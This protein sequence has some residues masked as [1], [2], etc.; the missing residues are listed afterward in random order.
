MSNKWRTLR[1]RHRR[2]PFWQEYLDK[3][4]R[5]TPPPEF[6]KHPLMAADV[7]SIPVLLELLRDQ[8]REIRLIAAEALERFGPEGRE[9]VP[10]LFAALSNDDCEV[11]LAVEDAIFHIDHEAAEKAG[12]VK[13]RSRW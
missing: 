5:R 4:V 12:L 8:D 2:E 9:A 10:A 3:L 7:E 11:R 13:G 1:I 6:H